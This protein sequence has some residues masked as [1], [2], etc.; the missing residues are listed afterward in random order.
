MRF[1]L[2]PSETKATGP[3]SGAVEYSRALNLGGL[4]FPELKDARQA[5]L[6]NL[7]ALSGDRAQAQAVLGL[8]QKQ[9]DDIPRN[10]AIGSAKTMLAIDRYTG[11]LF[12]A[13]HGRG[14]KGSA[15]EFAH[16]DEAALE[17]AR[18][19]VLIQSALF[20]LIRPTDLIPYYRLSATTRLPNLPL[21][22]HWQDA[23]RAEVE[24]LHGPLIDMRSKAYAELAPLDERQDAYWLEVVLR[25]S[26]GKRSTMNHYSKKSKGQL[27]HAALNA[28]R[29]PRTV[30]DLSLIAQSVGFEIEVKDRTLTLVVAL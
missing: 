20:G 4:G 14:L 8:S 18:D 26:T 5:V 17:R 16:L 24:S 9:L 21:R 1:L 30:S 11:T 12:D 13:I 25:D 23:Q 29:P 3:Y 27:L 2:P 22:Q 15:D 19:T 6:A 7:V 28:A 10:A